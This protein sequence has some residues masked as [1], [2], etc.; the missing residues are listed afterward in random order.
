M[1]RLL[2]SL[3]G[4]MVF[5]GTY[6]WGT[7]DNVQQRLL[8]PAFPRK[9]GQ[10]LAWL[11]LALLSALSVALLGSSGR[12]WGGLFIFTCA[13]ACGILP[14][15]PATVTV[16]VLALLNGMVSRLV[17]AN[18][19]DL[20]SPTLI[21]TGVSFTVIMQV[22]WIKTSQQL[23]AAREEIAHFAALEERLRIA[24]DL[25]DLLGHNLSLITLK[26][27]L[28]GH[29]LDAN[30]QQSAL[31]T[32]I[33]DIEQVARTTLQEV[34]EAVAGY[35]TPSLLRELQEA[36]AILTS[37]HIAY[38]FEGNMSLVQTLPA[39]TAAVLAWAVR[40]GV[41][42]VVRHSQ[43]R[44]CRIGVQQKDHAIQM[45]I[46]NMGPGLS[47]TTASLPEPTIFRGDS[48]NR[49]SGLHGLSERLA[50]VGGRCEAHVCNDGGFRLTVSVPLAPEQAEER[51]F[52]TSQALERETEK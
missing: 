14:F 29:F 31:A 7:W 35:R 44:W 11:S 22:Q 47:E 49:G 2:F 18:W 10:T 46:L 23:E 15:I 17:G 36:Q 8:A 28:A 43:A 3:A 19:L 20:V 42:N 48:E 9:G 50:A 33:R 24:R 52:D 41:T 38:R 45:E 5:L 37:A 4:P 16:T 6:L 1:P 39:Q 30:A 12:T 40:E 27:E 25:H 21:M 51:R 26:S 13:Y 32:E 34:R